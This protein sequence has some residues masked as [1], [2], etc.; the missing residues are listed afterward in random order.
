[1]STEGLNL[2]SFLRCLGR[3]KFRKIWA[4]DLGLAIAS[5]TSRLAQPGM[6]AD[7]EISS[8]QSGYPRSH[9]PAKI[10]L[11]MSSQIPQLIFLE[12]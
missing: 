1:V 8:Q 4:I 6:P 2:N 12:L 10:D 3:S 9:V 5:Q 11:P 7:P